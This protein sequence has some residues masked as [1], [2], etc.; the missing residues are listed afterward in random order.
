M[1]T[2]DPIRYKA[3]TAVF[4]LATKTTDAG[5]HRTLNREPNGKGWVQC[6]NSPTGLMCRP[7]KVREG[8]E[9]FRIAYEIWP[10]IVSLNQI[11]LGYEMIGETAEASE[12]FEKMLAQA[13]AEHNSAYLDAA[14]RGLE[15]NR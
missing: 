13:E 14:Q 1:P 4:K 9:Y 2:V 12:A 6:V 10:D 15:R 7:D 11:A 5:V 3:A 8:I